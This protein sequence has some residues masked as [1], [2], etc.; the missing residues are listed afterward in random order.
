MNLEGD[1]MKL[2]VL[3]ALSLGVVSTHFKDVKT[4][5]QQQVIAGLLHAS[6]KKPL[7]FKM[8]LK[9]VEM[10]LKKSKNEY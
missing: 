7:S 6:V 3:I 5:C 2:H 9:K 8:N 1:Y 10:N 4:V